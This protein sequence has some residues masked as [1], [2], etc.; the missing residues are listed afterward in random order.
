MPVVRSRHQIAKRAPQSSRTAADGR[1]FHSIAEM[2]RYEE[3]RR[4]EERG[5]IRALRCQVPFTLHLKDEAETPLKIKSDGYP[6]GRICKYT[7]D[8]VYEEL[9]VTSH[10][11]PSNWTLIYEE[12]KGVDDPTARLRRAMFEGSYSTKVRVTGPAKNPTRKKPVQ[13]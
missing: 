3:L 5:L 10:G 1:V 12:Y 4:L 11:Y 6:N 8:F 7:L 9:E 13:P 2:R